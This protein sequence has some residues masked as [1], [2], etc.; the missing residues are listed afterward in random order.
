MQILISLLGAIIFSVALKPLIKR[1]PLVFYG[2]ALILVV[3][4]L[5]RSVIILPAAVDRFIFI[6]M[7]K[8]HLAFV[9]FFIVMFIGVFSEKSKVRSWLQPIRAE[10]SII[11]CILSLGHIVA[12]LTSIG[13]R[14]FT[15]VGA[16]SPNIIIS[17]V[18][19]LV[20]TALLLVLGVTSFRFVK[21]RMS[22]KRWQRIQW[23]AY[24]FFLLTWVHI[25]LYLMPSALQGSVTPLTNVIVY[26]VLFTLY[27]VCKSFA[28][29]K[30]KSLSAENTDTN[31][32]S[33]R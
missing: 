15:N 9:F 28:I 19:S 27:I 8:A 22:T 6:M 25:L 4:F 12:Y 20:L 17:F 30:E 11:A 24:P 5:G 26:S 33:L 21:K 32:S 31:G 23:F 13:M 18:L 7:Q 29:Q 1:I 10:L 14:I 2:L 16:F 3:L